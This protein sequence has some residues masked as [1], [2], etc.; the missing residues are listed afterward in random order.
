ME[1]SNAKS[2]LLITQLI[3]WAIVSS[4][5]FYPVDHLSS[6]RYNIEFCKKQTSDILRGRPLIIS[7]SSDGGAG[8]KDLYLVDELLDEALKPIEGGGG[9]PRTCLSKIVSLMEMN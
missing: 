8:G 3:T 9:G 2:D 1:D 5:L 4:S 6:S 7:I